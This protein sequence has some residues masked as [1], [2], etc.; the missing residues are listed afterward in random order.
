MQLREIDPRIID[1]MKVQMAF[2]G[3]H[4]RDARVLR[5]LEYNDQVLGAPL[6]TNALEAILGDFNAL[7]DDGTPDFFGR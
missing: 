3:P 6:D 7:P 4:R 1:T 5:V 2:V